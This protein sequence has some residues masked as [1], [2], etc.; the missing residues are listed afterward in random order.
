M[1]EPDSERLEAL[2]AEIRQFFANDYPQDILAK[3]RNGQTLGRED[4]VRSQ[5][6]LAA[7][8]W[9]APHWPVAHGGP[10]WSMAERRLYEDEFARAGVPTI[11]PMGLIYVAPVLYTFG[12]PE[13]QR[14]WL[15]DILHSRSFWGQG[16]S[17]PQ[18]GSDLASLTTRAV[19]DGNEY[20]VT[21]TKTWTSLG[22]W[23]DWIFCLVRTSNE[24]RPSAG[25]SFLCIDMTSPGITVRPI[26]GLDGGYHLAEVHF[27]AVR[28]P[29]ANLIGEEGKGWSYSKYLLA[30]ERTWYA[31]VEEKRQALRRVRMLAAGISG[32][33]D[34]AFMRKLVDTEIAVECL[35]MLVA[36]T[37]AAGE[38]GGG[39]VASLIKI[40]ATET[41]QAITELRLDLAGELGAPHIPDRYDADWTDAIAGVPQFTVPA[42]ADYFMTRAQTI[43]GGTTEVQK[44]IIARA[45]LGL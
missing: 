29:V 23:A 4:T 13:Q 12:T 3:V 28:V 15:P 2:R 21:G 18:A 33:D 39:D 38:G 9:V 10:G 30:N 31:H 44:N 1:T 36:R 22:H 34:P 26:M 16:Y 42:V 8:G 40:L 25:I 35:D 14:R 20:V 37:L 45:V 19:R 32:T 11:V 7:R 17:E 27:E 24:N 6:A 43:Y 5:A 41:A